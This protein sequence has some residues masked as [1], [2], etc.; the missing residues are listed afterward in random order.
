MLFANF[1]ALDVNFHSSLSGAPN[2]TVFVS[3]HLGKNHGIPIFIHFQNKFISSHFKVV[4][5]P[6]SSAF[7]YFIFKLVIGIVKNYFRT[8][9]FHGRIVKH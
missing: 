5:I 8:D 3:P 4:Q 2:G 6:N 1:E 9:D 7:E